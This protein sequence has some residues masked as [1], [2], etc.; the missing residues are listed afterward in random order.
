MSAAD[1]FPD[2]VEV[3]KSLLRDRDAELAEARAA[4]SNTAALIAHLQL[5]IEKL[6]RE[7]YGLRSERKAR[8]LEQMELELEDLEGDASEDALTA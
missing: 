8:L 3:L 4:A 6:R 1:S 7:L 2:D 5:S